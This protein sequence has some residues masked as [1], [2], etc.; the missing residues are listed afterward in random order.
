MKTKLLIFVLLFL[1]FGW[2][3]VVN[4]QE[5]DIPDD[6]VWSLAWS[7]DGTHIAAARYNGTVEI[8][9]ALTGQVVKTLQSGFTSQIIAAAWSP[10]G[11]RIAGSNESKSVF[12]WDANT[13]L[14]IR[15]LQGQNTDDITN[16]AW[17]SDSTFIAGVSQFD[18][19]LQIWSA[20]TGQLLIDVWHGYLEGLDWIDNKDRISKRNRY[21]RARRYDRSICN[22]YRVS[23][24]LH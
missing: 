20:D 13:G 22:T 6:S 9:S 15:T 14:L 2:S 8:Q 11:T 5:V 23:R 21:W 3:T 16:L 7:P 24:C 10:D 4:A 17:S 1:L 18:G 12:L 19:K